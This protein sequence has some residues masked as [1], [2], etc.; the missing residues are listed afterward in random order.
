MCV[1][2]ANST[3]TFEIFIICIHFILI[4]VVSFTIQNILSKSK[5]QSYKE[6]VYIIGQIYTFEY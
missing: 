5:C 2:T 3:F 4:K 1:S 6:I